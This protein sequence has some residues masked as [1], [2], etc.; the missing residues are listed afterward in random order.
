[1]E[2]ELKF[3]ETDILIPIFT[4]RQEDILIMENNI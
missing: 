4:I 2:E 1:M 3:T